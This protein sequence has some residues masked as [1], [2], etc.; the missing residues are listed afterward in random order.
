MAAEPNEVQRGELPTA[1]WANSVVSSI[2]RRNRVK[3]RT[4]R[5]GAG[6]GEICI[7]G[8]IV[9]DEGIQKL[10]GGVVVCGDK[11]FNVP[12]WDINSSLTRDVFVY[13]TCPVTVNTDDDGTLLLPGV[14]TSSGNPVIQEN[15]SN[16]PDSTNPSVPTGEGTIIIPLGKLKVT[17]EQGTFTPAG[18]GSIRIDHCSGS[19][20]TVRI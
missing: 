7:F 18:C 11:N 15:S 12:N 16:Y 19:I 20:F 17:G 10:L 8:E 4:M 1:E 5:Y 2:Q 6:G 14:L 9:V 3:K 13:I